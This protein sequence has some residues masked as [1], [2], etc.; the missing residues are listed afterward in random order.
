[1]EVSKGLGCCVLR[2][3]S[4]QDMVQNRNA[5]RYHELICQILMPDGVSGTAF[6]LVH[7]GYWWSKL[8]VGG[9]GDD[10]C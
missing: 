4:T 5:C 2:C 10:D 1:M 6:L 9:T 3:F 8:F 7:I